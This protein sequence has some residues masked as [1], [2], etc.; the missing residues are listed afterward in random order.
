MR[1]VD[2]EGLAPRLVR[3]ALRGAAEGICVLVLIACVAAPAS[4]Q[5]SIPWSTID[6][7]G[8]SAA[9]GGAYSV[10]GTIGQPDAGRLNGGSYSLIGGFWVGGGTVV[11]VGDGGTPAD[12][13]PPSFRLHA[14]VPNPS[15]DRTVVAFDLPQEESVHVRLYDAT[16]RLTRTLVDG[17]FPAGRH[18]RAWDATDDAGRRI[19]A[20][21]YFVVVDAG[22]HRARQK[23]VVAR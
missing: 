11:G 23:I 9:V 17:T 7:G 3:G 5:Y 20:G 18:E 4:A 21:V 13:P 12:G 14:A 15:F 10:S 22:A 2:R 16:G 8:T 19:A 6:G 1:R